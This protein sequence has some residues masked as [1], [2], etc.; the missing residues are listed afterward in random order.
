M[1]MLWPDAIREHYAGARARITSK[2]GKRMRC[3]RGAY[4]AHRAIRANNRIPGDDGRAA[5]EA[6]RQARKRDREEGKGWRR[7]QVN[8]CDF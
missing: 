2:E 5:I 1:T 8:L 4:A 7:G 6:N 3:I